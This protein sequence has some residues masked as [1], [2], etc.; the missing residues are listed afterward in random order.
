MITTSRR[1]AAS[2]IASTTRSWLSPTA[3]WRSTSTPIVAS[4]SEIHWAFVFAICPSSS[5]VPTATISA[6]NGPAGARALG[7]RQGDRRVGFERPPLVRLEREQ[8]RLTL[9]GHD[10]HVDRPARNDRDGDFAVDPCLGFDGARLG[11]EVGWLRCRAPGRPHAEGPRE[12]P[13]G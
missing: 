12:P 9:I 10:R 7:Q 6:R 3:W 1:A 4:C 13:H 5:S 8:L 11:R 2:T